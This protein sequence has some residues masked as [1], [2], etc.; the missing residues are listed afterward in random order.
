MVPSFVLSQPVAMDHVSALEA[1][2]RRSV[3]THP[4]PRQGFAQGG[5]T[6]APTQTDSETNRLLAERLDQLPAALQTL[7]R[8]PIK[9]YTVYSELQKTAELYTKSKRIGGKR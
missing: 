9:A 2:R 1:L 3:T 4:L 7:T 8:T 6:G 5:Y